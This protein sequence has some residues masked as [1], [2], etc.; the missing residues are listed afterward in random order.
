MRC[1][2]LAGV[3]ALAALLL[4][5]AAA[6]GGCPGDGASGG[7]AAIPTEAR[8][9]FLR[10]RLEASHAPAERWTVAWGIVDGALVVGQLA[11]LPGA[12]HA[13]RVVLAAGAASGSLFLVQMLFAPVA[14]EVPAAEGDA[15]ATLSSLEAAL[16]RGARN[17]ALGAGPGAQV[18]NLA[19]NG[20]IGALAAWAA[21]NAW[22]GALSAGIGWAIGEVQILT[23]PTG[24]VRDLARYRAGDLPVRTAAPPP[25]A[26]LQL[27]PRGGALV[28]VAVAF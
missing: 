13:D 27:L 22:S 4:A 8:I 10:E 5:P 26:R 24:L 9:A 11:A 1:R 20:A 16:E 17:Q 19:I 2:A 28:S 7:L 15:C 3:G 12:A 14:V 18:G 25:V 21:G 6:Q 23:Q